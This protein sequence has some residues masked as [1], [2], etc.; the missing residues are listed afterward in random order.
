MSEVQEQI[1][2]KV[3][4]ITRNLTKEM[5]IETGIEPSVKEE[6]IQNYILEAINEFQ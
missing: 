1:S 6:E 3:T 5:E 2:K 4:I